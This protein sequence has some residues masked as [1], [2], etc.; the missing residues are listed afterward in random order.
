MER[1]CDD[2]CKGNPNTDGMYDPREVTG[3][4]SG[5]SRKNKCAN[6]VPKKAPSTS[7]KNEKTRIHMRTF[8][9]CRSRMINVFTTRA[10]NFNSLF[11]WSVENSNG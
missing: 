7:T 5:N 3:F 9:S 10:K 1:A 6:V 2:S 4:K 11:V 8:N